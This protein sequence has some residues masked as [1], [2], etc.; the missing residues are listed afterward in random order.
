MTIANLMKCA[1]I[2]AL[3]LSASGGNYTLP[4]II[5]IVIDILGIILIAL[6]TDKCKGKVDLPDVPQEAPAEVTEVVE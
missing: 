4:Y 3:A 5:F 1:F 2:M 6:V